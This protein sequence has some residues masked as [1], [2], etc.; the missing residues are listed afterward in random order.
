MFWVSKILTLPFA[1]SFKNSMT[2]T[3]QYL[4]FVEAKMVTMLY[5]HVDN[6]M[7][8]NIKSISKGLK[9][10]SLFEAL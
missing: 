1:I 10:K 6:S 2:T 9:F 7:M 3:Y 4:E 5:I 8:L